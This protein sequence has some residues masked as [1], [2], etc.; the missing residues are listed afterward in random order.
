M[1]IV[2]PLEIGV[3]D[4]PNFLTR[5][6]H[7]LETLLQFGN[8]LL[9]LSQISLY[10]C[11]LAVDKI[12]MLGN[13][14]F[15]LSQILLNQSRTNLCQHDVCLVQKLELFENDLAF[16]LLNID[17]NFLFDKV[18]ELSAPFLKGMAGRFRLAEIY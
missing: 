9:S 11:Q 18:L 17:L 6:S 12:N 3:V 5:G 14:G 13:S 4:H 8:L 1:D 16:P 15:G 10:L 7:L 2:S